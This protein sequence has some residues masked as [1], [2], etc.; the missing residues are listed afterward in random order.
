MSEEKLRSYLLKVTE[1]LQKT[2]RELDRTRAEATEPIAIVGMGCRYP[3]GVDTPEG[4]WR[5]V[6]DRVD[7]VTPFPADR[8]WD[9]DGLYDPDPDAVGTSYA[10]EGGFLADVAGFDAPFFGI[11]RREAI[12]MDPQQRLLLEVAWEALEHAGIAPASL[13][14]TSTGVFAGVMYQDY[15]RRLAFPPPEVEGYLGAGGSGSI[16]SGRIAYVLGLEGP[17]VTVDTA[18]SSSLVAARHAMTSLRQGESS[19]ALV[20]GSMVMSTPVA[21]VDF[22]RQ[23]GL[24]ADGRCKAF[25][26]GAD[27][28]GWGEGVGVLVLERLSSARRNGR[29]VLAL[30]EGAAINQDG[31]SSGLTAPSGPSQQRVIRAALADARIT[32]DDVDVVEGHGT[33]TSLGDPIEAQAVLATYGA[34]RSAGLPPL[35]LGSL[36]SNIAHTQAAAGVGGIIK[37]VM[38]LQN[39]TIPATLHADTA[40]TR[41]DWD[42]GRVELA[43]EARPWPAHPDRPRRAAVSSFGF[44][45]TNAHVIVREAP[46][47]DAAPPAPEPTPDAVPEVEPP[48]VPLIVSG[49][50]QRALAAQLDK[51]ADFVTGEATSIP[52]DTRAAD[53]AYSCATTR[54]ALSHRWAATVPVGASPA[55]IAERLRAGADEIRSA[56]PR[57]VPPSGR[58]AY[59]FSGQGSQAVGMGAELAHT[60]PVFAAAAEEI[61]AEIARQTGIDIAAIMFGDPAVYA[62][63]LASTRIS[64]LALLTHE[65]AM[66]RLLESWSLTAD[67]LIGH[68]IG[69]IAAAYVAGVF[70]LPDVVKVV[71]ARGELMGSTAP[72]VMVSVRVDE[73]EVAD[74]LAAAARTGAPGV[75]IAAV[76]GPRATVIS[77]AAQDVAA[78][79]SQPVAAA[80]K[81]KRL[82]TAHAFHSPAMESV[83]ERFGEILAGVTMSAPR[84]K[85][86]STVTGAPA[87]AADGDLVTP[88][89]WVSHLLGSVRFGAAVTSALDN[90]VT[91]MLE[92]GPDAALTSLARAADT[93]RPLTAH[94]T[95]KRHQPQ[96]VQLLDAV[97]ALH[98]S[99]ADVNWEAVFG[100]HHPRRVPLPTYAF[101]R[102]RLWLEDGGADH[103]GGRERLAHPILTSATEHPGS[104]DIIVSGSLSPTRIPWLREHAVAGT[105]ILPGTGFLDL[106]LSAATHIGADVIETLTIAAPLSVAD[107]VSIRIVIA[108]PDADDARREVRIYSRDPGPLAAE[109]WRLHAT[110]VLGGSAAHDGDVDSGGGEGKRLAVEGMYQRFADNGFD[111]GP[112]FRA[113]V[114]ASE[115]TGVVH[116]TVRLAPGLPQAG[117]ALHPVF[118]DAALHPIAL[119][120]A[121]LSVTDGRGRMP[122]EFT[123]V[124]RYGHPSGATPTSG[125]VRLE[126]TGPDSVAV[127]IADDHGAPVV[128][129]ESLVLRAAS[130]AATGDGAVGE[131]FTVAQRPLPDAPASGA[132]RIGALGPDPAG[133]GE[134]LDRSGVHVEAY[135]DIPVLIDILGTGALPPPAVYAVIDLAD[136]GTARARQLRERLCETADL[137]RAWV[138]TEELAAT[139]LVLVIPP[140]GDSALVAGVRGLIRSAQNENPGQI[141]VVTL[142]SVERLGAAPLLT[143]LTA[144]EHPELTI[145]DDGTVRAPELEPLAVSATGSSAWATR[146]SVGTVVVTG[147]NGALATEL[148]TH[149]VREHRV[150]SLVL[151][152]RRG[153]SAPGA[154]GAAT[155]LSE[156]GA[157]VRHLALD[158]GDADAVATAL[159]PLATEITAVVHAAGVIDDATL[160]GVDADRLDRVLTPKADGALALRSVLPHADLVLFSSAAGT[161]GGVGQGAYAAANSWL[162]GFAADPPAGAGRV[163]SLAWGPWSDD[164]GTDPDDAPRPNRSG[165][166][167][168]TVPG[169]LAAFDGALS[170][171]HGTGQGGA[172]VLLRVDRAGLRANSGSAVPLL[173]R[174]VPQRRR[175]VPRSHEAA[176]AEKKR[177]SDVLHRELA[178]VLGFAP[179][180]EV[181]AGAALSDLGFDSLTAVDLRNR[182][183]RELGV[184][185]PAT[186]VFDHETI[187]DLGTYLDGL[188]DD[189]STSGTSPATTSGEDVAA[190]PGGGLLLPIYNQVFTSGKWTE[191]FAFLRSAAALRPEFSGPADIAEGLPRIATLAPAVAGA[192]HLYCLPSCIAMGGIHQY[193]RIASALRGKRGVSAVGIPGFGVGESIPASIDAVVAVQGEAIAAHAQAVG[194]DP[195][196][197]GSSAGGWFAAAVAAYL[198]NTARTVAGVVLVD[199]YLPQS[200]L[201]DQ[202]GLA[203]MDGMAEREGTFVTLTDERLSAMGWYL[204]MWKHW[205]PDSLSTPTLLARAT[206]PLS[207]GLAELGTDWRASWPHRHHAIDI[208]G[209]H[210]SML[211]QHSADSAAAIDEWISSAVDADRKG[212]VLS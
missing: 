107:E 99:G 71:A 64:Q 50:G 120:T 114:D 208:R 163:I 206:E 147:A 57:Q 121:L 207:A 204:D 93:E 202:F 22:A 154:A 78:V 162:D 209:N 188:I 33:G 176:A 149:L 61:G 177:P 128:T 76:N 28:T 146:W 45:G 12:A 189:T 9:L 96:A 145:A 56:P 46:T 182:L 166:R 15:G 51:L 108:P 148:A 168:Y 48:A 151:C 24:A 125:R 8:G 174:M 195:V 75:A 73:R 196:L 20:T 138:T 89:Y 92:V 122:F 211:E 81:T 178:V 111:Y 118:A 165:L 82:D 90:G 17:A 130:P 40:S 31:A 158:V 5:L 10:R 98:A 156:L 100:P 21:F 152:S 106:A 44:S 74:A 11:S 97:G 185:L 23:R 70:T 29:R 190:E 139:P 52:P 3:G 124:R 27:G 32:A 169:G 203:L 153:G 181:E 18:C 164:H 80:W 142:D 113:V 102:E 199:T 41:V 160:A 88:E 157:S 36:K 193:A 150:T 91:R 66:Y 136:R 58:T 103:V 60:Y 119:S 104:G 47:D 30:L 37:M 1:D 161:L 14:G 170:H 86:I 201:V 49:K 68:S 69:E 134:L 210:F 7:A 144:A 143:A 85:V 59:L 194:S 26:D 13:A 42:S 183:T 55:V 87:A 62:A 167:A 192:A 140:S 105:P 123:G 197:L 2:K 77:G 84:R 205:Q 198:E 175:T 141:R 43:T 115:T 172:L 54:S 112:A 184:R 63:E 116:A 186:L 191:T 200:N 79:L 173:A 25:S 16:A 132:A 65:V 67:Y 72:G 159:G 94:P 179:D 101:Q 187:D 95:Q 129:I 155:T 39:A 137:L 6:R 4:L 180:A 83:A 133:I 135:A 34:G 110:G 19:L 117:H 212:R 109:P 53:I 126:A 38:S 127:R 35:V 131:F 171:V